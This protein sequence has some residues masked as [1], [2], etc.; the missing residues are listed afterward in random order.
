MKIFIGK[1]RVKFLSTTLV[2]KKGVGTISYSFEYVEKNEI[3]KI[4]HNYS[5]RFETE[6]EIIK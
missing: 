5:N 2:N 6:I 4:S 1:G 3:D